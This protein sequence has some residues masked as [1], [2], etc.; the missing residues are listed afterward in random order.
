MLHVNLLIYKVD[1]FNIIINS[2]VKFIINSKAPQ[3]SLWFLVIG[4]LQNW[5]QTIYKVL[6]LREA[7]Q[8]GK[9]LYPYVK[10]SRLKHSAAELQSIQ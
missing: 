2:Y 6:W 5:H 4:R 3:K 8:I 1:Q 9:C 10:K 7:S